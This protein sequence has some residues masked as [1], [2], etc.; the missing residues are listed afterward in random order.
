M[1]ASAALFVVASIGLN[2]AAMYLCWKLPSISMDD[3]RALRLAC[4]GI[5]L[6][7]IVLLVW[8]QGAE[9]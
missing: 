7:A 4:M 6:S 8:V 2:I 9:P 3:R 1:T 5:L